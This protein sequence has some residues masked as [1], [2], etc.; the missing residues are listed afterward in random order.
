[1][2]LE[3]EVGSSFGRMRGLASNPIPAASAKLGAAIYQRQFYLGLRG[4]MGSVPAT[5]R[6]MACLL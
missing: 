5:L 4:A 2:V 6:R 3:N 1:M